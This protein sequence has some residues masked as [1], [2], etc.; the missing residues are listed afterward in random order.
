MKQFGLLLF[1]L[2]C[3][4]YLPLLPVSSH[5]LQQASETPLPDITP[6]LAITPVPT[7]PTIPGTIEEYW[8][9]MRLLIDQAAPVLTLLAFLLIH[10]LKWALPNTKVTTETIYKWV[11]GGA[12]TLFT[13]LLLLG[14]GNALPAILDY[15]RQPAALLLD[16]LM[17]LLGPAIIYGVAKVARVPGLGDKQGL[18]AFQLQRVSDP[19]LSL[20]IAPSVRGP[21]G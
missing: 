4:V 6:T 15:L 14:L 2:F 13:I 12:V 17:M 10:V 20:V 18:G 7:L 19:P 9:T 3:A 21:Q 5:D 8:A 11:V 16:F 1:L